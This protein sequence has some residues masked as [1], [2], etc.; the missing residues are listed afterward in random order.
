MQEGNPFV[1]YL[2]R[3]TT[4]SSDHEAAFDEY[5]SQ[6]REDWEEDIPEDETLSLNTKT[7]QFVQERFGEGD[8]VSI[9]LTGNA[10]DGKTYL[11]RQ[12]IKAFAGEEI[13]E[14]SEEDLDYTIEHGGYT[15]RVV[16]DISEVVEKQGAEIL[17]DLN[18]EL[19]RE[20]Q[21]TFFLIAANEGRMRAILSEANL[22]LLEKE[23]S[24]QLH[25][26]PQPDSDDLVVLNL[27]QVAT[28]NYVFQVVDWISDKRHWEACDG[29]PAYGQ[30]PIRFNASQMRDGVIADRLQRLYE[31]LEHLGI[32]VTIRD[33]LIHLAFT[34]TAGL[35]CGEVI[36]KQSDIGWE[37]EHYAYYE[38]ALGEEAEEMFRQKSMV[39][40][41][42]RALNPGSE[43]IYELDNL[44]VNGASEES[45]Q[46]QRWN[47]LFGDEELDLGFGRFEQSRNAYLYG[48]TIAKGEGGE[49]K[50]I[51]WLPHLRRKML[52]EWPDEQQ[53]L[54]LFPFLYLP[55][56]FSLLRGKASTETYRGDVI[57]GLNRAFSGLFL[58]NRSNLFVTSYY[59]QATE[60][61]VPII[62]LDIP[63]TNL[64]L[65]RHKRRNDALDQGY[66]ILTLKIAPPGFVREE[67]IEWEMDLLHFEYLMRRANGATPNILASE[68]ELSIRQLR[69]ELVSTF[70]E[71]E[72]NNTEIKFFAQVA[73][74]YEKRTVKIGQG[75]T[76]ETR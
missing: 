18:A 22:P 1:S 67:P 4:V 75:R 43:S 10:G 68:C 51:G 7:E 13:S 9:I 64:R 59:A 52:F 14:W 30:C 61:A 36:E 72:E 15:L 50:L 71:E 17:K 20:E 16:K 70:V 55:N 45:E 24:T 42:L 27:N 11:C 2:N 49:S 26:G 40:H 25:E 60:Q 39:V 41:H 44:I 23:V 21:T 31:I 63:E 37:P 62:H 29:C 65:Q 47:R 34:A 46:E 33:M 48:K 6:D 53:V 8:P 5:I 66:H 28:S 69:D 56:Y 35:G 19:E 58:D 74:Q 38:N 73:G 57:L 54:H 32:H 3:Y 76:I 12:I